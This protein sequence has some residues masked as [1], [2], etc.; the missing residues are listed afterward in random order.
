MS[1]SSAS[2]RM[3][4]I[5]HTD[6]SMDVDSCLRELIDRGYARLTIDRYRRGLAH[7]SRW[8]TRHRT[9]WDGREELVRRFLA[10]HRRIYE[11]PTL[12]AALHHLIRFLR[13][14]GRVVAGNYGAASVEAEVQRFD[15]YLERTCG[16]APK[17]RRVRLYFIR[18]FLCARFSRGPIDL[19]DCNPKQIR[20][21]V[22]E[23][24]Q[25]WRP[26]SVAVLCGA[27]RSYL[28]FRAVHGERTGALIAAVPSVAAWRTNSLPTPLTEVE[29]E[30][31]LDAFDCA[32]PEGCRNYAIARCLVDLGLRAGE[33]ASLELEDLNWREGTL[34]LR[35]TK[36]KRV[37]MLPIPTR[38]GQAIVQYLHQRPTQRSNRALFV[39]YRPPLDAPLTVEIVSWAMHQAY[40]R[41]GIGKP[42][43]GT[44]CLRHSLACH[45]VNVGTPLKEIADL[46][47]HRSLNTTMVYAK[48]NLAQLA[49]VALPWPG[50]AL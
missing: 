25:G 32:T 3:P 29:I 41:A 2:R 37:D 22:T 47:R 21:F 36:G 40:D 16:L 30:R 46:L 13:A 18:R 12:S 42:W 14:R 44:H 48:S 43:A 15:A 35:R 17:T 6:L 45:L 49:A 31:F 26:G 24:V 34:R 4:R 11:R 50:R 7:F 33:V 19:I 39:R 20:R 27:I 38:T 9:S 23:A 5:D 1:N 8:V 28:R 10:S